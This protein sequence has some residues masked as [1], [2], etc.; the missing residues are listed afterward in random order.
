MSLK[1]RTE[2]SP[3]WQVRTLCTDH[4]P[5]ASSP[6]SAAVSPNG[7][8]GAPPPSGCSLSSSP[9]CPSPSPASWP[10]SSSGSSCR[11]KAD[12]D[13]RHHPVPVPVPLPVPDVDLTLENQPPSKVRYQHLQPWNFETQRALRTTKGPRSIALLTRVPSDF[14]SSSDP[15]MSLNTDLCGLVVDLCDLRVSNSSVGVWR[16]WCHRERAR[17]RKRTRE[18]LANLFSPA[19]LSLTG[20]AV[21]YFVR[22]SSSMQTDTEV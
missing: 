20:T 19:P 21:N 6:G 4:D 22:R 5:T 13:Q 8:A 16:S 17:A 3:Q 18:L 11:R 14:G 9:S 7:S 1:E 10:I 2:R 15:A 12:R